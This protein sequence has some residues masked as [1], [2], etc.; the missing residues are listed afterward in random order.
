MLQCHCDNGIIYDSMFQ[1]LLEEN[2]H[3]GRGDVLEYIKVDKSL[4]QD[5]IL[6]WTLW[7]AQENAGAPGR[8]ICTENPCFYRPFYNGFRL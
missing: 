7:K 6:L 3:N 8:D 2:L 4:G 5:Q 1:V